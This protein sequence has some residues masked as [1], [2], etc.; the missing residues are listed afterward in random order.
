MMTADLGPA[1]LP[2]RRIRIRTNMR[3][4]WDQIFLAAPLPDAVIAE[5]VKVN[6][7]ALS[8]AHLHRR[9]FPREH[10]PDGRE[11]K[12]YDYGILDN[13]QP[14]KAMAGAYTRFG[15]VTD[16][17]ARAD[18]RFVIF[19][20]G[21]EV[22]LEF[23][24][25]GLPAV[26]RGSVRGF[27]LYAN[28]YCKDMD[29]HT[30]FPESVEPLPFHGMSAYPYGE[31][32]SYPEDADHR[33][34]Q[35]HGSVSFM[36]DSVCAARYCRSFSRSAGRWVE[37]IATASSAAF[38]APAAPMA[39]APTGTPPGICTMESSESMPFSACDSPG[40]PSTGTIVCAATIPG[41]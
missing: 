13:T 8:G 15:R 32:E 4:F 41:R 7:V 12:I 37:T 11:P 16:L 9:G 38:F 3:V 20:K 5:K 14:F 18:D 33:A 30:A 29:P 40:T 1:P 31:G 35:D 19:G 39:K 6:E 26:P 2:T 10:S 24:T 25:K 17:L 27:L 23:P 22:T 28:G 36:T 34:R 21:E